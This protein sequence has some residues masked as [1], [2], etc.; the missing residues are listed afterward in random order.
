MKWGRE[1]GIQDVPFPPRIALLWGDKLGAPS[2]AVLGKF[3]SDAYFFVMA[4]FF[5]RPVHVEP[6]I[7]RERTHSDRYTML[8]QEAIRHVYTLQK[9]FTNFS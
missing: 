8:F 3:L 6:I 7:R 5:V 4:D 2:S 9:T 1:K